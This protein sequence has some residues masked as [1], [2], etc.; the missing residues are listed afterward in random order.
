LH[1]G[2]AASSLSVT[3]STLSSGIRELETSLGITLV[4]RTNRSVSF[5]SAG[6]KITDRARYVL[7]QV[8]DLV[9]EAKSFTDPL[10][11]PL[12]LGAIPTIAAF[13]MG[14]FAYA[15]QKASPR[16]PLYIRENTTAN[17]IAELLDNKLDLALLALPYDVGRVETRVIYREGFHLAFHEST[18]LVDLNSFDFDSLPDESLLL[19]D[20]GHC[21]RDHALAGCRLKNHKKIHTFGANSLQMLLQ[22]VDNDLGVTLVP[23]MALGLLK[24]TNIK[25]IRLPIEEFYRDIGF[26]WRKGHSR[27][28]VLEDVMSRLEPTL[29][30]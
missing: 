22:M 10:A 7:M 28:P 6:E 12:K 4:E 5:T 11:L 20:D 17:L 2:K 18:E 16:L 15:L 21:L 25:T 26:A 1:F 9:T 14:D 13:V 27:Q 8:E 24:N 3:Q 19:L 30:T 23:D 29:V